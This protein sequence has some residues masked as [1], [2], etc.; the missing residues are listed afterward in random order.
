[1]RAGTFHTNFIICARAQE[2]E[3]PRNF[4]AIMESRY[5]NNPAFD[6]SFMIDLNN[7]SFQLDGKKNKTLSS[8][9]SE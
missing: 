3:F 9:F 6:E 4:H 7:K 2:R 1:M 8:K 5:T